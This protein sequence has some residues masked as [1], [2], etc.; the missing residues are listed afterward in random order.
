M[1]PRDHLSTAVK[2]R[3]ERSMSQRHTLEQIYAL[4]HRENTCPRLMAHIKV[5]GRA[6]A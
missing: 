3:S 5:W 4:R 2:D 6:L 1:M